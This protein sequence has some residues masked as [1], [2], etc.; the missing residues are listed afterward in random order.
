MKIPIRVECNGLLGLTAGGRLS[1]VDSGCDE[2]RRVERKWSIVGAEVW[3]VVNQLIQRQTH[4]FYD[5]Q[6]T[7]I[8]IQE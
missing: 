7:T 4:K 5:F 3:S 6:S 2:G 8:D 1:N